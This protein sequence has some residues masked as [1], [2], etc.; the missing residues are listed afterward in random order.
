MVSAGVSIHPSAIVC[1]SAVLIGSVKIGARTV[2]HPRAIIKG[3][4]GEIIIGEDNMIE[5]LVQIIAPPGAQSPIMIGSFNLFE[6]GA[7]IQASQ[8]RNIQES[9]FFNLLSAA[10]TARHTF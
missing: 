9:I 1:D 10:E 4:G 7:C 2:V 8:V 6:V 5:E 3:E